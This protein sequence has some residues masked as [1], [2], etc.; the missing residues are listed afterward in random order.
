MEEFRKELNTI[1]LQ[2]NNILNTIEN[3][4]INSIKL[5]YL[6]DLLYEVQDKI[7]D[8]QEEQKWI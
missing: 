1:D 6:K 5:I 7:T 8:I 4:N 3:L 2:I